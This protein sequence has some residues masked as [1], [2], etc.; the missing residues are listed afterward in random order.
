MLLENI[1]IGQRIEKFVLEYREGGGWKMI[2]KGTTVGYKR[3]LRFNPVSTNVVRLRI[4]SSRLNPTI[5]A[6]GLYKQAENN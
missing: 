6:I 3:L 5:A 4:E 2:C 1:S